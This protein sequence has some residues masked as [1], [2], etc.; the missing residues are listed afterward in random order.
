MPKF[1]GIDPGTRGGAGLCVVQHPPDPDTQSIVVEA[2]TI[3]RDP[4]LST[5]QMIL[6]V[7]DA[8]VVMV[9]KHDVEAVGREDH[10]FIGHIERMSRNILRKMNGALDVTCCDLGFTPGID[11]H[12][13]APGSWKV[14]AGLPGD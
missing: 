2:I 6:A 1:L 14:I 3:P 11:Y 13:F 9:S 8:V 5:I 7:R 12:A 10:N 4:H